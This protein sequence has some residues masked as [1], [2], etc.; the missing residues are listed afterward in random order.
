LESH[1]I[2]AKLPYCCHIPLM[3]AKHQPVGSSLP[4]VVDPPFGY[5]ISIDQV[6]AQLKDWGYPV[7]LLGHNP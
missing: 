6:V 4:F 3:Q 5:A 1:S 7:N 2:L